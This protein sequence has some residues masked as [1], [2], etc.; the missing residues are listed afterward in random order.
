[1]AEK[2]LEITLL[3]ASNYAQQ[4]GHEYVTLEHLLLM[5]ISMSE[6][7]D[8]MLE[9]DINLIDLQ[10][11]LE[12][13]LGELDTI[14]D[15][16]NNTS[17]ATDKI[18]TYLEVML[19][20][21]DIIIHENEVPIFT[22]SAHKVIKNAILSAKNSKPSEKEAYMLRVMVEILQEEDSMARYLL[23]IQGMTAEVLKRYL[24]NNDIY[25]FKH[26]SPHYKQHHSFGKKSDDSTKKPLEGY[27]VDLTDQAKS[28]KFDPLIG[29]ENEL[30]RIV[31]ILARRNKNNPVLVGEAGVGKTALVEGLAQQI[32]SAQAPAFLKNTVIYELD[33]GAL[34][35]GT[36][37]RGD[38][39]ERLKDILS[40]LESQ[41]AVLFIDEIH[42]LVGAGATE[43]SS[44]DAANMLK[45]A[46]GRG[47]LRL[48]GA[49]THA[50]IRQLEKDRAL[51]RRFQTV[52]VPEPS[53]QET[54][55]ILRGLKD[56]YEKH[57]N[58]TYQDEALVAAV[59][60]SARYLRDRH[61]PDK[62]IDVLDESGAACSAHG[63]TGTIGVSEIESTVARMA[64]IP[65]GSV[66][67]EEVKSLASLESNLGERVFGQD[68]AVKAV[69]NA[70]K[71]AR[72]GLRNTQKPQG[73]FL[74]AGP[75][76]VGKTELARALAER[77]EV[78]LLRFDMS[79]YQEAHA[80]ARLIGSPPGYVGFEQ[81]GLLTSSIAKNPHA[82]LLLDEIEK[83]HP[84]IY[85]I[86]LQLMD[87]G[88]LTDQTGKQVDARGLIIIFTSNAGSADA[89]RAALG[90]GRTHRTGEESEAV[91]RTFSPEFRN[92]LDSVI[93][94]APLS[95]EVMN[96]VIDKFIGIL[97]QQLS[98]RQVS[99]SLSQAA[100]QQ[101]THLGYDP[102]MGAR[103]LER[104]IEEKIKR[105]LAESL[106]FGQLANGGQVT[107][108]F[109][110]EASEF[111][112]DYSLS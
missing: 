55:E 49:T 98:E 103:P 68:A 76:G 74:F 84:D 11:G 39:E 52:E 109:D 16:S 83:A 6:V 13:Y 9:F 111:S 64:R 33:V 19:D 17:Y 8:A 42:T 62:A 73:L 56:K 60:L 35:A 34:L 45:P 59:E 14:D 7:I 5:M 86:F 40:K 110:E 75:T 105:P 41:D 10:F 29:R 1:M 66:K 70:I 58:I 102:L 36:R 82:V 79:E 80:V 92:R 78:E 3:R 25:D 89:S 24:S 71:L 18:N 95:A 57:H 106:L 12:E 67:T 90:F 99:L 104:V 44:V 28:G 50:E 2:D 93:H 21:E 91:K 65:V 85:N 43:G 108:D 72:A 46:L 20:I 32:A 23:E 69:A 54:I 94:F 48:L 100:R 107:V 15:T 30:Q 88:T 112:F 53:P 26:A 51:W 4:E 37:Y 96:S 38:F 61:L 47:K 63:Q 27:A 22:D 87:H 101:L 81:G 97:Q 77:L 31:H